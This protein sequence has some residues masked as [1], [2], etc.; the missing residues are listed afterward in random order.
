M[1][2]ERKRAL[3]N[4]RARA[5]GDDAVASCLIMKHSLFECIYMIIYYFHV[6]HIHT[7]CMKY[8]FGFFGGIEMARIQPIH[9]FNSYNIEPVWMNNNIYSTIND[10]DHSPIS[11]MQ[12]VFWKKNMVMMEQFN[13]MKNDWL[14]FN[15]MYYIYEY[16]H[17]HIMNE[18]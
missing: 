7:I 4:D 15:V 1:Y 5:S 12:C 17:M 9:P 8:I 18:K 6:H 13:R 10:V 3:V 14:E 11:Y 2:K 16:I